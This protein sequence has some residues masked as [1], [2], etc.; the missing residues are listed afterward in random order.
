M[1]LIKVAIV[2]IFIAVLVMIV[3]AI[4]RDRARKKRDFEGI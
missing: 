4:F 3:L 2:V 1:T